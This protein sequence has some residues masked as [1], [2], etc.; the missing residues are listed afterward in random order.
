MHKNWTDVK[1]TVLCFLVAASASGAEPDGYRQQPQR[2]TL[3]TLASRIAGLQ[4]QANNGRHE[5]RK[6]EMRLQFASDN[7]SVAENGLFRYRAIFTKP[8]EKST[9]IDKTI[10]FT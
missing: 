8:G 9:V 2:D 7:F 4:Q 3:A 1:C 6:E 10:D 5:A